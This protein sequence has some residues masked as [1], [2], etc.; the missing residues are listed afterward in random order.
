VVYLYNWALTMYGFECFLLRISRRLH[1][2]NMG[3]LTVVPPVHLYYAVCPCTISLLVDATD[4]P[5]GGS[6]VHKQFIIANL[7]ALPDFLKIPE[8]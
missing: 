4:T 7:S 3:P 5:H 1:V 8:A 2:S 6:R